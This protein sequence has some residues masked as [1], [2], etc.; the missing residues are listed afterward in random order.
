MKKYYD[1][2]QDIYDKEFQLFYPKERWVDGVLQNPQLHKSIKLAVYNDHDG[3]WEIRI[4][5]GVN[6]GPNKVEE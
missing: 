3:A 6:I 5:E 1:M 4:V 2:S